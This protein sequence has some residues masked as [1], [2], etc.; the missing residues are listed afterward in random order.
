[1]YQSLLLGFVILFLF[2]GQS[3]PQ[4]PPPSSGEVKKF[5]GWRSIKSLDSTD[6]FISLETRLSISL[7]KFIQG[8]SGM[9]PNES[10]TDASGHEY[11]WKFEET[12]IVFLF[13][14]L[15]NPLAKD[16]EAFLETFTAKSK[17]LISE[18]LPNAKLLIDRKASRNNIPGVNLVY[19]LGIDGKLYFQFFVHENRLY[20]FTSVYKDTSVEKILDSIYDS[21]KPISDV[22]FQARVQKLV[23][24]INIE[25]L[26]QTPKGK[27]LTSDLEDKWLKGKVNKI[28]LET[29]D[30]SGTWATQGKKI[31]SIEHFNS[32]GDL[33]Q[34]DSY[35]SSGI[36]SEV[37]VYGYIDGKRVSN[38]KSINF[39]QGSSSAPP[40]PSP[41]VSTSKSATS[42]KRDLRYRYSYEFK[43]D[44]GNLV[45]R[46]MYYNNGEKG[47]RYVNKYYDNR[48]EKLVYDAEGKLNQKYLYVFDKN[49]NE[50]EMTNF[51]VLNIHGDSDRRYRYTYDFDQSGNWIK[52][53][54]LKE[55]RENG[56]T[57]WKPSSTSY[58]TITYY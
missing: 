58:R 41:T 49:G 8:Y 56:Q 30:N 38:H 48:M 29:E 6:E 40:P 13:L 16:S 10:G 28:I 52:Q 42:V 57:I 21:F 25:P 24:S 19:D 22:E 33:V 54:T 11:R 27:R 1:M 34:R 50:I 43:Y 39:G 31:S 4:G 23:D 3:I 44:N 37:T 15:T 32:D 35:D 53:I 20:R 36:P 12:D 51:A 18:R 45:E 9:S 7:P 5:K 47:M 46:Q 26:P 2:A 14:N 17:D 55:H